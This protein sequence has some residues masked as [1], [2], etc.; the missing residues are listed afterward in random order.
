MVGD[1][2]LWVVAYSMQTVAGYSYT[3]MSLGLLA[4]VRGYAI[5]RDICCMI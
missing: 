2:I 5:Q 4:C 1:P 3:A